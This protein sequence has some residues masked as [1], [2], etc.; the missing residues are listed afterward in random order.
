MEFSLTSSAFDD[1]DAIPAEYTCDGDNISPPLAL[2]GVP[3]GT[4]S[5]VLIC[6]DPDAPAKTW[7]HWV[8]YDLPPTLTEL[9]EAVP[10]HREPDMGGLHGTNDFKNLGYGGPCPPA[11][12]AHHYH[13][14]LYA[15]DKMLN[16]EPG[17]TKESVESA[18]GEHLLAQTE[19]VGTYE[20]R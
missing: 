16:L 7:V 1:G 10:D 8:L 5:L 14:K 9:H 6:D 18:M 20:R 4:R 2:A 15:L 19:L 17:A 3:D 12:S 11:G 13:F